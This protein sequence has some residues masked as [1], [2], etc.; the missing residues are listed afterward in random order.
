MQRLSHEFHSRLVSVQIQQTLDPI[1][2]PLIDRHPFP[3]IVVVI[4]PRPAVQCHKGQSLGSL[5]GGKLNWGVGAR[6]LCFQATCVDIC[7]GPAL[8]KVI[9]SWRI[10]AMQEQE[11]WDKEAWTL[12][13]EAWKLELDLLSWGSPNDSMS[14]C[15]HA[16]QYYMIKLIGWDWIHLCPLF[17]MYDR[18]GVSLEAI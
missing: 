18:Q 17:A 15:L 9:G 5:G 10:G 11:G 12:D 6:S 16:W 13:R 14:V 4:D 8:S 7:G 2:I 1:L 3:N